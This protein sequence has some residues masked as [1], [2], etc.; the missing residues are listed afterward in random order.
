M[1]LSYNILWFEDSKRFFDSKKPFIE[2]YLD[3]L[4]FHPNIIRRPNDNDLIK[5][6]NE[7]DVDLILVDLE[8]EWKEER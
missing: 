6:M 1:R 8:S 7:T 2:K 3:D 4:G 5:T